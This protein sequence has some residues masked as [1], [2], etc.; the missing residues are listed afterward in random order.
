MKTPG[1]N[2][3]GWRFGTGL[4]GLALLAVLIWWTSPGQ[5]FQKMRGM[6]A[7]LILLVALG[8]V[9]HLVKALAWRYCF[10]TEHRTLSL[11]RLFLVRLAGEAVSQLTGAGQLVGETT[12][13]WMVK[14]A[15]PTAGSVSAVIADRA[16]FTLS[17]L[18]VALLGLALWIAAPGTRPV[19]GAGAVAL[20]PVL[21][22]P[23]LL[24]I[25][26]LRNRWPFLSRVVERMARSWPV[27]E[28]RLPVIRQ[29]EDNLYRLYHD[30]RL[31]FSRIL[32]LQLASQCL[33]L[34]EVFL[35]LTFL[36]IDA[37][38]FL[39]VKIEAVAKCINLLGAIVPGNLGASE[40]G[41]MLLLGGLGLGSSNGL[42]LALARRLRGWFWTVAGL[43]ILYLRTF[44]FDPVSVGGTK[45]H[46]TSSGKLRDGQ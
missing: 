22:A 12:R 28:A 2:K 26:M 18:L 21:L 9:S 13:A 5:L 25:L 20:F 29:I 33:S 11:T 39:T 32:V 37:D 41:N 19:T 4:A 15:V 1:L 36:G 14:S 3:W 7:G 46:G 34:I 10:S 17:S 24:W 31:N 30:D 27:W 23:I 16:M 6:G 42:A 38:L 45:N 43:A 44:V 8:G 40:A 35:V